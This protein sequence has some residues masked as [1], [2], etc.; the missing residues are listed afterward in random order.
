MARTTSTIKSD[1]DRN[2]PVS[3][4]V[5][6]CLVYA[7]DCRMAFWLAE[8]EKQRAIHA[9]ESGDRDVCCRILFTVHG[10]CSYVNEYLSIQNKYGLG[11]RHIRHLH[12]RRVAHKS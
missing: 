4:S 5:F 7:L 1:L 2:L 11:H 10:F 8:K 3:K 6:H 12:H 9:C